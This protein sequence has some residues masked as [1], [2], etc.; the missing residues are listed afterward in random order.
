M[1]R[2]NLRIIGKE[3]GKE[4]QFQDPKNIFNIIIEENFPILIKEIPI[5]IQE[6]YRIL[7]SLELRRKSSGHIIIKTKSAEQRKNIKSNKA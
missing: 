3:E 6:A 2:F 7:T 5:S 4:S 1:K